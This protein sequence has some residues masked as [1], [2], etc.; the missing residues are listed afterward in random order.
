M[1]K[2]QKKKQEYPV[3]PKIIKL[4]VRKYS[5]LHFRQDYE[6]GVFS[7]SYNKDTKLLRLVLTLTEK[8]STAILADCKNLFIFTR[9]LMKNDML[10]YS[11][12]DLDNQRAYRVEKQLPDGFEAVDDSSG[13]ILYFV[14]Q[15]G[16]EDYYQ[17]TIYIPL[18]NHKY[19]AFDY[20][21]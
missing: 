7:Y 10:E 3:L 19:L 1:N 5:S 21:C 2:R 4:L 15:S 11:C 17:G 13:K 6:G 9:K 20:N 14:K 12:G 18:Q 8:T 16:Y